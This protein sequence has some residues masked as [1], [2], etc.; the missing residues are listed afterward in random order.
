MHNNKGDHN[1]DDCNEEDHN[2]ACNQLLEHQ[3]KK[4]R[5]YVY[6]R[7]DRILLNKSWW[8]NESLYSCA[9]VYSP[10]WSNIM[11]IAALRNNKDDYNEDDQNKT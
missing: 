6:Q 7:L 5:N 4:E 11:H 3:L 1:K 8:E 9:V 10:M 2:E